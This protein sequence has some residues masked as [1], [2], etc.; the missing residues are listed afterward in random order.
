MNSE[1][2]VQVSKKK[3]WL[4]ITS[5]I[6]LMLA[7]IMLI[8]MTNYPSF[9]ITGL[10]IGLAAA[11]IDFIVEYKGIKRREWDYASTRFTL[12]GVPLQ[13]PILFFS[14]GV[15]IAFFL[16]IYVQPMFSPEFFTLA[17]EPIGFVQVLLFIM[18]IYYL[19]MYF[20]GRMKSIMFGILPLALA[21]YLWFPEPWFL[22]LAL[23]PMYLDYYLEKRMMKK[24][25]L[26]YENHNQEMAINVALCYFPL[27]LLLFGIAVLL[28]NWLTSFL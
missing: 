23:L 13:L 24:K 3:D 18:S 11:I 9:F 1:T 5:A 20:A 8:V 16:D 10:I 4:S 14:T 26:S 25:E 12:M 2:G 6:S 27:A 17:A 15:A 7:I 28:N 22:V 19:A 21:I